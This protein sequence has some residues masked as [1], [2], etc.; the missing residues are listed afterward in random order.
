[1]AVT[2]ADVATFSKFATPTGAE[3][4]LMDAMIAAVTAHVGEHYRS[5]VEDAGRI[6]LAVTMQVARLWRRRDTPEGIIAFDELGA[7]RVSRM[8]PDVQELLRPLWNIA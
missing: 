7:V 1:M 4:T 6:D 8:D 5:D 2:A 3:L